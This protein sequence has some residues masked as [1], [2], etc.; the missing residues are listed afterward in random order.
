[1]DIRLHYISRNVALQGYDDS[2][3]LF[4]LLDVLAGGGDEAAMQDMDVRSPD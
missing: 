4:P 3:A 2:D 1:M